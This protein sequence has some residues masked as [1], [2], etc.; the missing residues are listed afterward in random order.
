MKASAALAVR[1]GIPLAVGLLVL[2]RT[3]AWA[4]DWPQYRGLATDGSSP[5]LIATAWATNSPG[6]V[7]WTN[8]SLTNGLGS[9][10]VSQGRAFTQ[11]SKDDGQ[12]NLLEYCVAVDVVT[13]TNIWATPIDTAQ[14]W[15]PSY[16][17]NGGDGTAPYNTGDGPRTTPSVKDGRVI[18]FSG[19][20]FGLMNLVCMNFTNGSV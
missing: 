20:Y 16:T 19:V 12:G 8:R 6:F 5:D 17:G 3:W 18:A 2:C 4:T 15:D 1:T 13:G 14:Q 7:V 9:F 10:A 11:I